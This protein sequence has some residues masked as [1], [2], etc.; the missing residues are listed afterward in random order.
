VAKYVGELLNRVRR[1]TAAA[2]RIDQIASP[3]VHM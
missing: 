2:R 1:K 3:I